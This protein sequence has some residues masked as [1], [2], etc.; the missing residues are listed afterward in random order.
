MKW[1]IFYYLLLSSH[2]LAN[3]FTDPFSVEKKE[4][5]WD[6]PPSEPNVGPYCLD[7]GKKNLIGPMPRNKEEDLIL[8]EVDLVKINLSYEAYLETDL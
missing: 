5:F 7:L 6:L 2:L 8:S 4:V 1:F 3:E